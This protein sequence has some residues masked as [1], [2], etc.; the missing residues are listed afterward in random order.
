M[1]KA[2]SL[3]KHMKVPTSQFLFKHPPLSLGIILSFYCIMNKWISASPNIKNYVIGS[4][5]IK[6]IARSI[7]EALLMFPRIFLFGN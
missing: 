6:S 3:S 2:H 7:Y 1:S 5:L 4:A